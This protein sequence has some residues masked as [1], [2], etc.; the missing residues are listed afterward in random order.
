MSGDQ[1]FTS[2][3]LY[4]CWVKFEKIAC[5][6]SRHEHFGAAKGI[7]SKSASWR[8]GIQIHGIWHNAPNE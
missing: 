7:G 1:S 2:K 4:S 5:F 6:R 3:P 8:A